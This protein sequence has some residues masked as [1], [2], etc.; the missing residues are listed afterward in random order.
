MQK[1]GPN[2]DKNNTWDYAGNKK[3]IYEKS[4]GLYFKLKDKFH[5]II[6]VNLS[7]L[8]TNLFTEIFKKSIKKNI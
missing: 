6:T 3:I 2:K 5:K 7:W 1:W 8:P 4:D